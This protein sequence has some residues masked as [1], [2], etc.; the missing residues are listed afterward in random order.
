MNDGRK[1]SFAA[2]LS[3]YLLL[4]ATLLLFVGPLVWLLSTMMKTK[5]ETYKVPPA[6]LP[7]HFTFEAFER[8]FAVQPLMWRWIQNSF[9]I[10]ILVVLGAVFSSSIVA[11]GFSRF[12]TKYKDRLFAIV[13]MTLMIPPSIM[14][15]PSYVLYTKLGWIDTWLPLIVP[16]WLGS[17]Y[18]IFLFRQF[19]LTIPLEL[20][21]ATYLD[22][23]NR[24][25]VYARVMMPL[26][27]PIIITTIIF[28]FVNSWLDFLGP[29]LYIKDNLKF[30]LSVGLQLLIG[31]TSQD[32]PA[33]AAGAFISIIPIGLL[34]L[35]AQRYIVEGVVLTGT[36][37]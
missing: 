11:Y 10:S 6:L 24:W 22:G 12:T 14:M 8:L 21:E 7:E 18:Y 31:Q 34:Y 26:S 20:D 4:S 27:K 9:A 25:T 13:L 32:F 29:F 5:A 3:K 33:L 36:K 30:T 17:A 23:G 15:I 37:G 28:A 35:F 1:S 19:F 16:A 2:I